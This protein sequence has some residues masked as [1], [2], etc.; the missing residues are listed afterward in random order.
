M[1]KIYEMTIEQIFLD[2][3]KY[4]QQL[5][6][7]RKNLT[8]LFKITENLKIDIILNDVWLNANDNSNLHYTGNWF[9]GIFQTK[10]ISFSGKNI[11][12]SIDGY[13]ANYEIDFTLFK[14]SMI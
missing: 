5:D 4:H 11:I 6:S 10:I 14:N 2:I 8:I 1:F 13:F 12:I 9:K 3:I 7:N